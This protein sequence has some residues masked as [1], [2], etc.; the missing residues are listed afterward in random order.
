MGGVGLGEHRAH[1][2]LLGLFRN[3]E[4]VLYRMAQNPEGTTH[5]GTSRCRP[6]W[7]PAAPYQNPPRSAPT[8]GGPGDEAASREIGPTQLSPLRPCS[9]KKSASKAGHPPGPGSGISGLARR[10]WKPACP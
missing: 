2:N 10:R 3:H 5:R 9:S 1:N 6:N 7:V 4:D 8:R